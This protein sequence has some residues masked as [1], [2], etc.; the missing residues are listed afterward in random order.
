M[1]RCSLKDYLSKTFKMQAPK[2]RSKSKKKKINNNVKNNSNL[3]RLE[4]NIYEIRKSMHKKPF[5]PNEEMI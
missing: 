1:K 3:K 5:Q 4:Q 2:S